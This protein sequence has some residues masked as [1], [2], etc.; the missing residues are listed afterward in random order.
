MAK[1]IEASEKRF[2]HIETTLMSQA[3]SIR[4]IEASFHTLENQVGQMAE[5]L[6]ARKPGSLPSNTERNPKEQVHAIFVGEVD[7]SDVKKDV[8]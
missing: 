1:F 3:T 6:S 5:M 7:H 2:T 8:Y 4:N